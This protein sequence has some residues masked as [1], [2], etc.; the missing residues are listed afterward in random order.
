MDAI[1]IPTDF[2]PAAKN[3]T[4]YALSFYSGRSCRF[5]LLN[6]YTPDFVHSRVMAVT[7]GSNLEADAMQLRSETGLEETLK[8]LRQRFADEDYQFEI[9]SSFNLLTQ[10]I[11]EQLNNR[12]F[13]LLVSGTVGCSGLKEVF[14]GSNT[15]RILRATNKCPVLVVPAE[16]QFTPPKKIG[17][18]TDFSRPY[19]S[20]QLERLYGFARRFGSQLEIMHIGYPDL[21]SSIQDFHRKQLLLELE[22][23]KPQINWIAPE[24]P[25]TVLIQDYLRRSEIDVLA[26]V[27]NEHNPIEELIREP[28]VKRMAFHAQVP[29]LV[30][31]PA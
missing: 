26:M 27:R 13:D 3:A 2:S 6:T 15:V 17:F 31:P 7:Q 18:V 9:T 24:A 14:M 21:I 22:R 1:L 11:R 4:N 19:T 28:V 20:L 30:L 16:V 29:I 10:E 5:H 8:D 25:K 23:F 12:E